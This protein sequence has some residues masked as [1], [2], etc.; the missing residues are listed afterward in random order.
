MLRSP[1]RVIFALQ[2]LFLKCKEYCSDQTEE[3]PEVV[4]TETLGLKKEDSQQCKYGEGDNL[5]NNLQLEE[6]EGA[7]IIDKAEA[8]GGHHSAILKQS[9]EPAD[10]DNGKDGQCR[11]LRTE[12]LCL[13]VAIPRKGHK[14]I[15]NQQQ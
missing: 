13:Q 7:A 1:F 12:L 4:H 8:V 11:E 6:G 3:G 15:T 2:S 14:C 10:K 5:L 9:D